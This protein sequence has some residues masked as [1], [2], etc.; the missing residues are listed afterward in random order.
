MSSK[1][2]K[3]PENITPDLPVFIDEIINTVA[4]FE[5]SYES[6]EANK[7]QE[8]SKTK[9]PKSL[10]QIHK[11][12]LSKL[13]FTMNK[14]KGAVVRDESS[15][16]TKIQE[17]FDLLKTKLGNDLY[18]FNINIVVKFLQE[19]KITNTDKF[20]KS[21]KFLFDAIFTDIDSELKKLLPENDYKLLTDLFNDETDFKILQI[22]NSSPLAKTNNE[23]TLGSEKYISL[24]YL[25][26]VLKNRSRSDFY[27]KLFIVE[28]VMAEHLAEFEPEEPNK[29]LLKLLPDT[30]LDSN[31]KAKIRS[32]V[33]LYFTSHN[34][35]KRNVDSLYNKLSVCHSS[36]DNLSKEVKQLTEQGKDKDNT[37]TQLT[38]QG[39]EKD[40]TI[41]NMQTELIQT[42]NY[43]EYEENK[44]IKQLQGL[45]TGLIERLQKDI[46]MELDGINAIARR[47]PHDESVKLSRYITNITELL[48]TLRREN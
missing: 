34:D 44:C 10:A 42:K 40:N 39:K 19:Y 30:L 24:I 36:I 27:K 25:Y 23:G 41:A 35:L 15:R 12:N 22:I 17:L 37:I 13:L 2:N 31:I 32:F 1:S 18:L 8:Q 21:I 9:K 14:L 38:K 6:K 48:N 43:L 45:K 3:K 16:E 7:N 28:R 11:E 33:Y 20:D 29:Y 46:Q 26:V 5:Y 4:N 47:L